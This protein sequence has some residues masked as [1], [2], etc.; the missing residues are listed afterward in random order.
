[1]H[2]TVRSIH[3]E[4]ESILKWKVWKVVPL[5]LIKM[6]I[7]QSEVLSAISKEIYVCLFTKR[8]TITAQ[9]LSDALKKEANFQHP[10]R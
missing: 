3:F 8:I 6:G 10:R 2:P 4:M 5:Y 9:Y 1:M 7:T